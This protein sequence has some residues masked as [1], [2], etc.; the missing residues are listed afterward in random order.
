MGSRDK[1]VENFEDE[2]QKD[3]LK[4][5]LLLSAGPLHVGEEAT[6]SN[7]K[8]DRGVEVWA[9]WT[10]KEPEQASVPANPAQ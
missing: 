7:R 4:R 10:P 6:E 5:A 3:A 8:K 2:E 9:C 1:L